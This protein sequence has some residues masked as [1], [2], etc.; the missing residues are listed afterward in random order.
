MR[1]G[2]VVGFAQVS[3]AKK[4]LDLTVISGYTTRIK[5]LYG[6]LGVSRNGF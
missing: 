1:W 2:L 4:R 5:G 3:S 6:Y